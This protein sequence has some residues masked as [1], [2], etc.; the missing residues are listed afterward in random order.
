MSSSTYRMT[1]G[2]HCG[3]LL[4]EFE[5]AR[6]MDQLERRADTCWFCGKHGAR[7]ISDPER[8]RAHRDPRPRNLIRYRFGLKTADFLVCSNCGVY[9]AAVLSSGGM[10]YATLNVNTFDSAHG[11]TQAA[12][13]VTYDGQTEQTRIE[14]RRA[15]WTP[16]SQIVESAP[17]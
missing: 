2:C 17:T 8:H 12:R 6:S 15:S 14:R 10:A 3:N 11:L 1:G 7:T 9:V 4:L 5:T 16:V 13:P